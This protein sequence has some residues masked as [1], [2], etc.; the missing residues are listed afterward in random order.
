MAGGLTRKKHHHGALREALV[1]AGIA[2]LEQGGPQALTLRACAAAA[3]VSHAAPAHHFDGLPGLRCAIA[4][5][6]YRRFRN[7]MVDAEVTGQ[8]TPHGRLKSICRG[9]LNFARNNKALFDLIF[10]FD[11][12]QPQRDRLLETSSY[13]Y[14]VLRRCCAPLVPDGADA[15][16]IETQVWSLIHGFATLHLSGRFQTEAGGPDIRLFDAVMG[17]LDRIGRDV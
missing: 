12:D 3:G 9:Y 15:Q 7:Y 5:E 17:M 14:Q 6:G 16:V 4:E 11:L 10:G 8:Q 13:G 2:L 1:M